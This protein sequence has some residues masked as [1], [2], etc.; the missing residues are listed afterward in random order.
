MNLEGPKRTERLF[1]A[2]AKWAR[3]ALDV[4]T[5]TILD[6]FSERMT[7]GVEN[8]GVTEECDDEGGLNRESLL[9]AGISEY[10]RYR[11]VDMNGAL[12]M[13]AE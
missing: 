3:R 10:E 8:D 12:V 7:E 2:S 13:R 4:D 11:T 1:S 9:P 5:G 6:V